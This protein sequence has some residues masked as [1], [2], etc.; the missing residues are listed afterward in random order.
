VTPDQ[1]ALVEATLHEVRPRLDEVA[2]DFYERLVAADPDIAALF[3]GD[4]ALQRSKFTTELDTI[5]RA[6]RDHTAFL[7]EVRRLGRL[8]EDLGVRSRHYALAGPALLAALSGALGAAWTPDVA[9]AWRLA[10]HLT[11]ETMM[12]GAGGKPTTAGGWPRGS[13]PT[14]QS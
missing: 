2:A 11:A 10:H 6:I 9:Q 7:A 1:I 12:T 4:P 13:G 14:V 8:H 5:C 3:T